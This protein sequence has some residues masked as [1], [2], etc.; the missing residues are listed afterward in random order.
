MKILFVHQ[1]FPG[2]F[3]HLAPALAARGHQVLALTD[4][5]N[6]RPSPVKMLRYKA[7]DPVTT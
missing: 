3:P 6:Q 7:P 5:K 2:Q 1:N 4:E